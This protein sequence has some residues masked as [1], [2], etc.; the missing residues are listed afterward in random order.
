MARFRAGP[1]PGV[2]VGELSAAKIAGAIARTR[3]RPRPLQH[4]KAKYFPLCSLA[5]I[6][7][8]RPSQIGIKGMAVDSEF[9]RKLLII[10][11][12]NPSLDRIVSKIHTIS[13]MSA[14]LNIILTT[15]HLMY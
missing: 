10:Q 9:L 11:I 7:D 3:F 12:I 5:L 8:P 6:F 4:A 14:S 1:G 13:D 15:R 2:E